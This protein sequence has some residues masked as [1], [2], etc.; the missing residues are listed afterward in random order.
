MKLGI[1]Q[2]YFAPYIG[3][4]QLMNAVDKYIVYDDVNFIK[5]GWINRNQILLNSEPHFINIPMIGASS[6]KLINEIVVNPDINIRKKILRMIASS[7]QKAPFYDSVYPLME[8]IIM[9]DI[10]NL[11]KFIYNSFL[12]IN[13]Y[14]DISTEL[15]L[16]S[17]IQKDCSLRGQD[18]VIHICELMKATDYYNAIGG[19]AL[20]SYEAFK[21]KNIQLHFLSTNE[22]AYPQ[23][24]NLFVPNLSI[25]DVMMFNPKERINIMLNDYSLL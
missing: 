14:L 17:E 23:F 3:Y 21:A 4:W 2:P 25:I 5:G 8:S 18:K 13:S 1:M 11:S 16:S 12:L 19:Q 15:I 6:N 9:A 7:Y 20:Y 24:D 22:I 10:D